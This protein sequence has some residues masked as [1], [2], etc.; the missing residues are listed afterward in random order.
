MKAYFKNIICQATGASSV[1][2]MEEIQS[3]WSGYGK[4]L[5]IG[6]VGS[7]YKSVVVKYIQSGEVVAIQEVGTLIFLTK[8]RLSLMRW[9]LNGIR[10]GVLDA[11]SR[12][13]F[14]IAL[15]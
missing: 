11:M 14:L 13:G 7:T 1:Y 8:E 15:L 3:L 10:I 9:S 4:I 6:L 2:E 5:R 12:V